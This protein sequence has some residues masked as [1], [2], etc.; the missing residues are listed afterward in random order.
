MAQNVGNLMERYDK[1]ELDLKCY[2][3]PKGGCAEVVANILKDI[4]PQLEIDY[5]DD[6]QPEIS[7][8]A[9]QDSIRTS[10]A[11]CLVCA[12]DV[13]NLL[14]EKCHSFKINNVIDGREFAAFH[15]GKKIE[16][17]A[18]RILQ[19]S[20]AYE[21]LEQGR[22]LHILPNR[23]ITHYY[24]FYDLFVYYLSGNPLEYLRKK[25][26]GYCQAIEKAL[27]K[28]SFSL[29]VKKG[30]CASFNT[31]LPS[32][33]GSLMGAIPI[34]YLF[35]TFEW[36]QKNKNYIENQLAII[37]QYPIMDFFAHYSI[38]MNMG[39]SLPKLSDRQRITIGIGHS[40]S[41]AFTFCCKA[42]HPEY[43]YQYIRY[44]F[45]GM[46]F[47][48]AIDK[49]SEKCYQSII[50]KVGLKLKVLPL[51]SPSL[52]KRMLNITQYKPPEQFYFLPRACPLDIVAKAIDVLLQ[53]GKKVTFRPHP[54]FENFARYAN[55][56]KS[57]SFF[58]RFIGHPL[59]SI[60]NAP[61]IPHELLAKSIVVTDNS[62][63]AYS[64]PLIS[65]KPAILFCPPMKSFDLR[66]QNFG[67]SF[68]NPLLHRVAL[69]VDE[70]LDV[71]L[72]LEEELLSGGGALFNVLHE[73]RA[74]NVFNLG[75]SKEAFAEC[76]M[77]LLQE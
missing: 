70:F 28:S 76:L 24:Y 36:Y 62:S 73:W 21:F 20:K 10:G 18:Q 3:Y 8:E 5:V 9:Q 71:A 1:I 42:H 17:E 2:I 69:S 56:N 74:Q 19:G 66:L 61:S 46:D 14:L 60:D 40:F 77:K 12:G 75:H 55:K 53:K 15:L 4:L 38:F 32:I 50:E 51:G 23:W 13:Q 72:E 33:L 57:N 47:Y 43:L 65:L 34:L 31:R 63:V 30:I 7:L 54:A 6:S 25:A 59:F 64:A 48:V 26:I 68:A 52:D 11:Y 22:V 27:A 39:S 29:E 37:V 58:D 49:E 67:K 16:Q 44:Y 41:D 45:L 35:G